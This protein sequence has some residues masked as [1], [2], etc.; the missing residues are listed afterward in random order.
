MVVLLDFQ[1]SLGRRVVAG[2]MS[3]TAAKRKHDGGG[4]VMSS[5]KLVK[6]SLIYTSA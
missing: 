3:L 4:E 2:G 6:L 5:K 1:N